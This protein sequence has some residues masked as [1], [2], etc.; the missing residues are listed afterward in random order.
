MKSSMNH[1]I[2][3]RTY[4]TRTEPSLEITVVDA[5]LATCAIQPAFLSVETGPPLSRRDLVGG[6]MGTGNPTDE[7]ISEAYD[8]FGPNS[9]VSTILSIGS[10]NLGSL[11][12]PSDSATNG[13]FE[14]MKSMI[15][16]CEKTDQRIRTQMG[17]LGVY[18][19]FSV[20]NG[21][22]RLYGAT[23]NE[24]DRMNTLA[25]DYLESEETSSRMSDCIIGL[26]R[27]QGLVTLDRISRSY[28]HEYN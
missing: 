6:T 2:N 13:W 25:S 18:H 15:T 27:R 9:W 7:L 12:A 11:P 5:I 23:V 20:K 17:S 21:L 4:T 26:R 10:G 22:Q 28:N 1:H 14:T 24:V 19:R 3:L 8:K 16:E